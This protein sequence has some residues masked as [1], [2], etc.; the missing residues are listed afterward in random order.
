MIMISS[1]RMVKRMVGHGRPAVKSK[2]NSNRG[3]VMTLRS[4]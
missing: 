3:V 1:I 2:S 4:R